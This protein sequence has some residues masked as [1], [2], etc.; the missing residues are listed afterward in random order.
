MLIIE[1]HNWAHSCKKMH[2]VM[3]V[4]NKIQI[5]INQL[6]FIMICLYRT[7]QFTPNL[8]PLI[9][10][11]KTLFLFCWTTSGNRLVRY[12]PMDHLLLLKFQIPR[13]WEI[14]VAIGTKGPDLKK[15]SIL[16]AVGDN[17]SLIEFLLACSLQI[18]VFL[19]QNCMD[20][21]LLM[22]QVNWIPVVIS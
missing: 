13:S 17:F 7:L 6:M 2:K 4:W 21:Q 1:I 20:L 14:L 12:W 19:L 5:K 3:H 18:P 10:F 9:C 8:L 16:V 15:S 11:K 22:G